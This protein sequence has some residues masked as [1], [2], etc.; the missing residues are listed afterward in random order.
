MLARDDKIKAC[1]KGALIDVALSIL[2]LVKIWEMQQAVD[3]LAVRI[4]YSEKRVDPVK[5]HLKSQG[6][7]E[8]SVT[9]Q[10]RSVCN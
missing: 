10:A 8:S 3:A 1:S 4:T 7:F 6:C 9:S 2:P 5:N